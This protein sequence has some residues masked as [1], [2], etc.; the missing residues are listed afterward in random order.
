VEIDQ[1]SDSAS[2]ET[3]NPQLDRSDAFPSDI[4]STALRNIYVGK[5]TVWRGLDLI[6]RAEPRMARDGWWDV[7]RER[8][9]YEP[10]VRTG[11]WQIA[12]W[13]RG[14]AANLESRDLPRPGEPAPIPGVELFGRMECEDCGEIWNETFAVQ[15]VE[16]ERTYWMLLAN[17]DRCPRCHGIYVRLFDFG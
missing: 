11:S 9:F 16:G 4:L 1:P 14:P 13:A 2:R 6:D 17:S 7:L 15:L 8:G 12:I 10:P 3:W 5:L